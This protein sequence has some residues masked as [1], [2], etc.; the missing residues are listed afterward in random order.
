MANNT[1]TI[2]VSMMYDTIKNISDPVKVLEQL[3]ETES[4]MGWNRV[5]DIRYLAYGIWLSK[6]GPAGWYDFFKELTEVINS[7]NHGIMPETV[8]EEPY[9]W[10]APLP[11]CRGEQ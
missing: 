8:P 3:S 2:E 4:P 9:G 1:K 7:L 10:V 11:Y 6:K 5:E